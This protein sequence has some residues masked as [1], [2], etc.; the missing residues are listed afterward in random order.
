MYVSGAK[1]S[2][3]ASSLRLYVWPC[4]CAYT[5]VSC[6]QLSKE[7]WIQTKRK[8]PFSFLSGT[9]GCVE[10]LH[11]YRLICS[12][13]MKLAL[14]CV[15]SIQERTTASWQI[16]EETNTSP[17]LKGLEKCCWCWVSE[18]AGSHSCRCKGA[19]HKLLICRKFTFECIC[20]LCHCKCSLCQVVIK[21]LYSSTLFSEPWG[22]FSLSNPYFS[23]E[24][25]VYFKLVEHL[26]KIWVLLCT[27]IIT[28]CPYPWWPMWW[29]MYV[30]REGLT[31]RSIFQAL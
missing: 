17:V 29:S 31:K 9:L 26:P 21:I 18:R 15:S 2:L 4:M 6:W 14:A 20:L 28:N 5:N 10:L 7:S 1:S 13:V 23:I 19:L 16:D 11:L 12:L 24:T 27:S 22:P 8:I 3:T 25:M 30:G